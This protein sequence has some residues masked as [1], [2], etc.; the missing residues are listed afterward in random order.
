MKSFKTFIS[1]THVIRNFGQLYSDL[2]AKYLMN[3][4]ETHV[5]RNFG[6]LYSD[7]I[8]KYLMN[9]APH[10]NADSLIQSL[11]EGTH[12][13]LEEHIWPYVRRYLGD[14]SEYV[15][16]D[17]SYEMGN[18]GQG[19]TGWISGMDLRTMEPAIKIVMVLELDELTLNTVH[20]IADI[21]DDEESLKRI[22]RPV[23]NVFHHELVHIMQHV[24]ILSNAN[25]IHEFMKISNKI[26]GTSKHVSRNDMESYFSDNMELQA[27]SNQA[28]IEL[29]AAAKGDVD[30]AI[31]NFTK[32]KWKVKGLGAMANYQNALEKG[33]ISKKTWRE[34]KKFVGKNLAKRKL[35]DPNSWR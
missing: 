12:E 7:L 27:F 14:M 15:L 18:V 2:I 6:Q 16:F 35:G 10:R 31:E 26:G 24:K 28:A 33:M 1:E 17:F 4:S 23:S 22:L 13:F 34:F 30:K 11:Q 21:L 29:I 19:R 20:Y 8:A 5:I 9:N 32:G 25:D 3:N